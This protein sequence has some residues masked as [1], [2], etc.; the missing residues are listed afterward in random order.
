MVVLPC[1]I[2]RLIYGRRSAGLLERVGLA[3]TFVALADQGRSLTCHIGISMS[4][5]ETV[6]QKVDKMAELDSFSTIMTPAT[7]RE[8]D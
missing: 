4:D 7:Q 6:E 2:M 1:F 5:I 3:G 8:Q